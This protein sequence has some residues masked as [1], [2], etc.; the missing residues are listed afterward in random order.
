MRVEREDRGLRARLRRLR[1]R[2][3]PRAR[4]HEVV[5]V[6]TNPVKVDLGRAGRTPVL[7]PGLADL[8]ERAERRGRLYARRRRR[9]RRGA[10]ERALARLRRHARPRATGASSLDALERVA[11]SRSARRCRRAERRH[12]VVVRSTVLPGTTEGVVLPLLERGSRPHGRASTSAS[13]STRSSCARE[14]RRR[15]R[16]SAEDRDRRARRGERRRRRRALR[17]P[18]RRRSS[19]FRSASPRWRST[20]TTR[21]TRSRSRSRTRSA[22]C[23]RAFGID[24]HEVMDVFLADRK[25]NIREAYLRPGFASAARACPRTCARWSTRPDARTSTCRCSRAS[26]RRTTAPRTRRRRPCI[27]HGRRR[28]GLFGLA[29]KPGTD[30][31]RESPL[32]ELAERL[33]GQGLRPP[34]LR[35]R[36]L[37]LDSSSARTASTSTST[38]R[39][40]R[41][42]SSRPPSEVARA[43][44]GVRRRLPRR[45]RSSRRSGARTSRHDHRPRP[46]AR[47]G[48]PA[49]YGA[50][51]RRRLVD[52]LILVE[53]L[54]VPFD[55]RVWQECQALADA[56]LRGDA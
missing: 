15:L 28:V 46:A 21:S 55:R 40:S 43:R 38:C 16:R 18:A 14:R 36:G 32:V 9:S 39:T 51:P 5:G 4:G 48:R 37:R 42:C 53:N 25:L 47:R 13:R 23:R 2:R 33:I 26:C 10:V 30:D 24:S 52:A 17:E 27:A 8:V 11:T 50:V 20:S 7:E 1:V 45:P 56:G 31:L 34:D 44:R 29:F 35:P 41:S 3:L 6:D 12:T 54:S 49:R 22:R 19:A